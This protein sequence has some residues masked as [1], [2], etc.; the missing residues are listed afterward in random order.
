MPGT[1]LINQAYALPA[2]P[3]VKDVKT[4]QPSAQN[5]ILFLGMRQ[6]AATAIVAFIIII[7]RPFARNATQTAPPAQKIHQIVRHAKV[8]IEIVLIFA[9]A[10][11]ASSKISQPVSVINAATAVSSATKPQPIAASASTRKSSIKM[12]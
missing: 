1:T 5:A 4:R 6:T 12:T 8:K 7:P 10:K 2:A 9:S 3:T 11:L